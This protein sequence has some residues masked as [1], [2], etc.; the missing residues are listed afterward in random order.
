MHEPRRSRSLAP[1]E[2]ALCLAIAVYLFVAV[3]VDVNLLA[4]PSLL[5]LAA[6][7]TIRVRELATEPRSAAQN[8]GSQTGHP[9]TGGSPHPVTV[10][11]DRIRSRRR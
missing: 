2:V 3:A 6:E 4:V 1:S 7:V 9:S 10:L 5:A 11:A 8:R